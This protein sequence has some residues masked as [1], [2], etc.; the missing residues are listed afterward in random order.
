MTGLVS[1]II[2]FPEQRLLFE[3]ERDGNMYY[4]TT[5]LLAKFL[6]NIPEQA[7]FTLIYEL[8]V[9]WMVGLDSEFYELYISLLLCIVCTGSFG[10]IIGCFALS[11]SCIC[12][13]VLCGK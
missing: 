9:Y 13:Y 5:W 8:I 1:T 11:I 4:T 7:L 6:V 2:V 10:M 3:R 12:H